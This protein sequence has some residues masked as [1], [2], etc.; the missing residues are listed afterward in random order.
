MVPTTAGS[1]LYDFLA[2]AL[3]G[4]VDLKFTAELEASLDRV[5]AGKA[6]RVDVGRGWW[7]VFAGELETAKGIAATSSERP[8]L[9]P[10]PRCAAAGRN[11]RL[12]LISGINKEDKKAFAFAGCDADSKGNIVCGMRLPVEKNQAVEILKCQ[13]CKQPMQPVE[14]KDGGRSWICA[15]HGWFLADKKWRLVEAPD[16]PKCSNAMVHRSRKDGSAFFWACFD[17]KEFKDA[18][19]FGTVI[20]AKRRAS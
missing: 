19:A 12:R 6:T 8:D 14:R 18:D 4:L 17:H 10:C 1:D 5:G 11:H 16:C 9:G 13:R 2:K 20:A 7:S 15:Q 3:P